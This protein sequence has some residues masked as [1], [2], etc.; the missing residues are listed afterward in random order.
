MNIARLF[1]EHGAQNVVGMSFDAHATMAKLFL[2]AFYD[3]LLRRR[4]SVPEAFHEGRKS[5]IDNKLREG[6]FGKVVEVDD[7][8]VPILYE[9]AEASAE[10]LRL[11]D[12]PMEVD[13]DK[14]LASNHE[15][16]A[17]GRDF[18]IL[19]IEEMLLTRSPFVW[20][21]GFPGV[22]KASFIDS[23]TNWWSDTGFVD[24]VVCFDFR[25]SLALSLSQSDLCRGIQQVLENLSSHSAHSIVT[26]SP[27]A[28]IEGELLKGPRTREQQTPM[29]GEAEAR[30]KVLLVLQNVHHVLRNDE[31]W[32]VALSGLIQRFLSSST[33]NRLLC[34]SACDDIPAC[35]SR[36]KQ[37]QHDIANYRLTGLD[38]TSATKL[39]A[40][41]LGPKLEEFIS[42]D[43]NRAYFDVILEHF[44]RNPL[45]IE[46]LC[47]RLKTATRP[48]NNLVVLYEELLRNI[49]PTAQDLTFVDPKPCLVD[50]EDRDI[51]MLLIRKTRP[52]FTA[53]F[54][55]LLYIHNKVPREILHPIISGTPVDVIQDDS[56]DTTI[57]SVF[58]TLAKYG[59]ARI[60]PGADITRDTVV[61]H[62]LLNF[63][64]CGAESHL[65][66]DKEIRDVVINPMLPISY[67]ES[68]RPRDLFRICMNDRETAKGI[69]KDEWPT[70]AT[71]LLYL[72][73]K[74]FN[75]PDSQVESCFETIFLLAEMFALISDNAPYLHLLGR[76][77]YFGIERLR[78][79]YS[80]LDFNEDNWW[81]SLALERYEGGDSSAQRNEVS[82]AA[83]SDQQMT[84]QLRSNHT[85]SNQE[86]QRGKGE[87]VLTT[88]DFIR[89]LTLVRMCKRAASFYSEDAW[90][91]NE[92]LFRLFEY[93]GRHGHVGPWPQPYL[94]VWRA[95]A[96]ISTI[97]KSIISRTRLQ[98]SAELAFEIKLDTFEPLG[99]SRKDLEDRLTNARIRIFSVIQEEPID[100]DLKFAREKKDTT[101]FSNLDDVDKRKHWLV[102]A[103]SALRTT[104]PDKASLD[105]AKGGLLDCLQKSIHI[106]SVSDQWFTRWYLAAVRYPHSNNKQILC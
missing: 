69:L 14:K 76:V 3:S 62:P 39:A 38:S 25:E 36:G 88:F 15:K 103:L 98:E 64:T 35:F 86:R 95:D 61:L 102:Q 52:S 43:L 18:D 42:N 63:C 91:W 33:G 22:G 24:Q 27:S 48:H 50:F 106:A 6:R 84:A 9:H 93:A 92:R 99:D 96:A 16:Q 1:L 51:A 81:E 59:M 23:T 13:T 31:S 40:R 90:M 100:P 105:Q 77:S 68:S 79:Y 2:T 65:L 45:A 104:P 58:Q 26:V 34:T 57:D 37:G 101:M 44:Q 10:C 12:N 94:N 7:W 89:L 60:L 17:I 49:W 55:T 47:N 20:L 11:L 71:M 70:L 80:P 83:V 54:H 74:P 41:L 67:L 97:E 28:I 8:V 32:Q 72:V 82:V 53:A 29:A 66:A 56:I 46:V 87:Y 19:V 73:H 85:R 21:S 78:S 4:C 5:L 30:Q 75:M